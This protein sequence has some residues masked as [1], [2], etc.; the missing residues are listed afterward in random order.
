[1]CWTWP[2]ICSKLE[3]VKYC[4][5]VDF[6]PTW[7]DELWRRA[8]F[9]QRGRLYFFFLK[10]NEMKIVAFVLIFGLALDSLRGI[11][12]MQMSGSHTKKSSTRPSLNL[13]FYLFLNDRKDAP[14]S[15]LKFGRQDS[16]GENPEMTRLWKKKKWAKHKGKCAK[17]V[18]PF[19][20]NQEALSGL[21]GCRNLWPWKSW[22]W[23]TPSSWLGYS[24]MHAKQAAGG[25]TFVSEQGLTRFEPF[26]F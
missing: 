10:M 15:T 12:A 2:S 24:V 13:C 17:R 14:L 6:T 11:S 25:R 3:W 4:W 26:F 23:K 16:S 5:N 7:R 22:N 21:P 8:H 19:K 1:M 20:V 9:K 18:F